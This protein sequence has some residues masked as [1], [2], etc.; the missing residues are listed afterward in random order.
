FKK[1]NGEERVMNC[2]LK[3][4]VVV[5]YQ[6][7]TENTKKQNPDVLPVWD[8]DKNEWRSF[9]YDSVISITFGIE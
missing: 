2:T 6:A 9:R 7:K 4:D 5:P 3:E 8:I 1:S